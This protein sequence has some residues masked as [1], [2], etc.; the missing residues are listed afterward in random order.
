M[1]NRKKKG[2]RKTRLRRAK[3]YEQGIQLFRVEERGGLA[4]SK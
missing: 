4:H 3:G 1:E 2:V